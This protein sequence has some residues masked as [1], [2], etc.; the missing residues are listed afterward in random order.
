ME[1]EF[2]AEMA[3]NCL[4]DVIGKMLI[5]LPFRVGLWVSEADKSG[6]TDSDVA[7]RQV[8]ET[9]VT[10]YAEDY[11]KSE[12]VQRSMDRT[13]RAQSQWE[14]WS[15]NLDYVLA[16]CR[17]VVNALMPIVP[18]KDLTAFKMNLYEIGLNVALAFTEREE[19]K[20][21]SV[22]DVILGL[23]KSKPVLDDQDPEAA[24][25]PLERVALRS[26]KSALGI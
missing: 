7:E 17:E 11:L 24:I 9:M 14:D 13:V 8:L 16:E 12:F 25:S 6:G 19:H 1:E 22:V 15:R 23:L 20:R 2:D 26:L 18:P 21:A 5:A 4:D 3:L 10:A